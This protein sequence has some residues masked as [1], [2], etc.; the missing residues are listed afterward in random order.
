MVRVHMVKGSHH[1][2]ETKLKL[3]Q[4]TRQSFTPERRKLQ[5]QRLREVWARRKE[6][7]GGR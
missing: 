4:R 5:S 7:D 3:S 1:S 6:S 2:T